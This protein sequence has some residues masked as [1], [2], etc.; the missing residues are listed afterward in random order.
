[1]AWNIL[2]LAAAAAMMTLGLAA[3]STPP[4][5]TTA[6]GGL[7]GT[8]TAPVT[9]TPISIYAVPFDTSLGTLDS[10]DWTINAE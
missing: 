9:C 3:D 5:E 7:C 8:Y 2:R 4:S 1:M 10:I 6:S